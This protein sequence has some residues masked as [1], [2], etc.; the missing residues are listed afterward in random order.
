MSSSRRTTVMVAIVVMTTLLMMSGAALGQSL[1]GGAIANTHNDLV[2]VQGDAENPEGL[3][4]RYGS[5]AIRET[6]SFAND[7]PD[8]TTDYGIVYITPQATIDDD[9]F[10]VLAYTWITWWPTTR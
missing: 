2:V 8:K 5:A 10:R 3:E 6:I 9:T 4:A 1:H 7:D